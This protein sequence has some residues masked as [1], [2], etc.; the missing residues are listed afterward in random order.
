VKAPK[1]DAI[2]GIVNMPWCIRGLH[3][4]AVSRLRRHAIED[5]KLE[6]TMRITGGMP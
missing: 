4:M 5:G 1:L 2:P 6:E 3:L